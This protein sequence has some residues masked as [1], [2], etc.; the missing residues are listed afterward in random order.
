MLSTL[1]GWYSPWPM[2]LSLTSCNVGSRSVESSIPYTTAYHG[3]VPYIITFSRRVYD[4][5]AFCRL[6]PCRL[7]Y[8]SV[9]WMK[10]ASKWHIIINKGWCTNFIA[11]TSN[12][13][14]LLVLLYMYNSSV[15]FG[16]WTIV[17]K[18]I[19]PHRPVWCV[20]FCLEH[21]EIDEIQQIVQYF[22]W[23]QSC[24]RRKNLLTYGHSE[25]SLRIRA[26][27]HPEQVFWCMDDCCMILMARSV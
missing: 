23:L 13:A 12:P 9:W 19:L 7:S 4:A 14:F 25:G 21:S 26:K 1:L 15:H 8:V 10:S 6:L 18:S 2:Y 3:T 27:F 5:I 20:I 16:A 24:S 17:L 22:Y 11:L